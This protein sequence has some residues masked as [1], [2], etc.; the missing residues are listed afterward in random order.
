MLKTGLVSI[1]F[2]DQTTDQITKM[3]SAAGLDAIEWGGDI[4]VPHG[5][6][7]KAETVYHACGLNGIICPSYGSYYRVGEYENPKIQYKKVLDCAIALKSDVVR[8]WAGTLPTEKA[9]REHWDKITAELKLICNMTSMEGKDVALEYHANTLTDNCTDTLKLL[10]KVNSENLT[11]YWQPPVGRSHEE[12]L[13]DIKLLKNHISNIHTFAWDGRER[14]ALSEGFDNWQD[15]FLL[16][17]TWKMRYCML[18]FIK[19]NSIEG[20]YEDAA[21]LKK[22][23]APYN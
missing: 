6:V 11:T 20:F 13:H 4:H 22:L 18:E 8:V 14:L 12:N 16:V 23:T 2:R 9:D 19:D 5:D 10:A 21:T 7:Y 1:S 15:Y 17:N 3:V